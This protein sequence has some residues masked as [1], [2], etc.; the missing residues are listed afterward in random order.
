[1]EIVLNNH[2]LISVI[3]IFGLFYYRREPTPEG[4]ILAKVIKCIC[5]GAM[6][7]VRG[8]AR[9]HNNWIDSAV[10]EYSESFVSDVSGFLKVSCSTGSHLN[11]DTTFHSSR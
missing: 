7:K 4:N 10:G 9:R 6:N 3:F 1:M 11:V 5:H 2:N 8:K